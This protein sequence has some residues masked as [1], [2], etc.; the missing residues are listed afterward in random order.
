MTER[1]HSLRP[2]LADAIT[3]DLMETGTA[4]IYGP[5]ST[6]NR[7]VNAIEKAARTLGE[8]V[9]W[10]REPHGWLAGVTA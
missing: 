6:A 7:V 10:V 8:N 9:T 5:E 4:R 2:G 1:L 3:I